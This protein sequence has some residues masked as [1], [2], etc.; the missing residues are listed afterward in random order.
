MSEWTPARVLTNFENRSGAGVDFF[1]EGPEL[2]WRRS[3]FLN[4]RLDCLLLIDIIAG[5]LFTKHVLIYSSNVE[6]DFMGS[7][8]FL[9]QLGCK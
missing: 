2:D 8:K 6:I 5:C 3:H 4:M 1:K 7:P 9:M